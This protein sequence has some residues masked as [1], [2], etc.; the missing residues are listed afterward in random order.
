MFLGIISCELELEKQHPTF[1]GLRFFIIDPQHD[2]D[3][4]GPV[5]AVDTVNAEVGDWVLVAMAPFGPRLELPEHLPLKAAVIGVV[6]TITALSDEEEEEEEEPVAAAPPRRGPREGQRPPRGEEEERGGQRR[7]RRRGGRE[8]GRPSRE[9]ARPPR[10]E[11]R[12]AP[13]REEPQRS[14]RKPRREEEPREERP[15]HREPS[16][17]REEAA[18]P[19]RAPREETP[20]PQE[21]GGSGDDGGFG[22]VWESSEPPKGGSPIKGRAP[23]RRR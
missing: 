11:D 7:R 8:E 21:S 20:A 10:R 9:E 19:E 22:I 6:G 17:R 15:R 4:N 14:E 1:E 5:I 3:W 12:P 23:R 16:P 2:V 18:A 13:A